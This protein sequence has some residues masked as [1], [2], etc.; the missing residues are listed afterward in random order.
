MARVKQAFPHIH[1]VSTLHGD[2]QL[3]HESEQHGHGERIAGWKGKMELL[4]EQCD[5]W[6]YIADQQAELLRD[7]Y[8]VPPAKLH[9]IYNGYEPAMPL[10][11][12]SEREAGEGLTF[13][14]VARGIREKGWDHLINAFQRLE[15]PSRL[16][17]VGE[18]PY[19]DE[20]R[21][22]HGKDPRISFTGF[23]PNPVE[24]IRTA[25]VF[26]FPSLY[27]GESLPTVVMEALYCG[28]PV[29]SSAIG[30]I[31]A[32]LAAP[33]GEICGQLLDIAPPETLTER[34]AEAMRR[35]L[36]DG[37]LLSRHRQLTAPAF[38]KFDMTRCARHYQSLYRSVC[39]S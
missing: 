9:K 38:E 5:G 17:L 2:Y 19:L 28:V 15:S 23:H 25:D 35:Y 10:P 14:M 32:M 36:D 11:A 27:G 31:P 22:S 24:L 26:V 6:A 33:S 34:L 16:L 3:F 8:G 37:Q 7:G 12:P 4:R 30:E 20:L 18:G 13:V 1:F 21:A 29:I 39:A